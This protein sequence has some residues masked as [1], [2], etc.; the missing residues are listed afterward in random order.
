MVAAGW[1]AHAFLHTHR[2]GCVCRK[3]EQTEER[4]DDKERGGHTGVKRVTGNP[5]FWLSGGNGKI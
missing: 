4:T 3:A 5:G 2:G 1:A